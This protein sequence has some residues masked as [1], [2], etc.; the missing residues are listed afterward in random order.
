MYLS[1]APGGEENGSAAARPP[2]RPPPGLAASYGELRR[3]RVVGRGASL[4]RV[5]IQLR[6]NNVCYG[7]SDYTYTTN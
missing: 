6:Q 3:G 5:M 1:S 4:R 7:S 2:W